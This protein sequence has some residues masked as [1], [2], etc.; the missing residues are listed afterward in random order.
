MSQGC[1]VCFV[2]NILDKD[3][4]DIVY[5]CDNNS[6]YVLPF[7]ESFIHFYED[8]FKIIIYHF[9]LIWARQSSA[10]IVQSHVIVFAS[11]LISVGHHWQTL[12]GGLWVSF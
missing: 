1:I 9:L 12:L 3:N 6:H 5:Y 7:L 4:Q 8:S 2:K 10:L 11:E